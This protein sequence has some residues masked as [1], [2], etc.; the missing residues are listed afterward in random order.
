ME[1][2]VGVFFDGTGNNRTESDDIMSNIGKLSHLYR[3]NDTQLT[4]DDE[5]S[6]AMLYVRGVGT[7]SNGKNDPIDNDFGE[8][9]VKGA[10]F[11][12]GG[13]E[14]IAFMLERLDNLIDKSITSMVLD[15]FGFS[16]GAALARSFVNIIVEKN[17]D[18]N[19]KKLHLCKN[20]SV[21]FVGLYDTVGSFG[22]PGDNDDPYNFQ[23]S[24]TK[25]QYIYQITSQDELRKNFDSQTLKRTQAEV[26][27]FP[28]ESR[29]NWMVEES[30]PG[31]HSDIGGGYKSS[32]EQG[33]DNNELAKI[34]L[35]KMHKVAIRQ[36]VPFRPLKDLDHIKGH[37][38]LWKTPQIL[39]DEFSTIIGAY[40]NDSRLLRL[41]QPLK[42]TQRYL[43]V[44][45][46]NLKR[47]VNRNLYKGQRLANQKQKISRLKS[48][49]ECIEQLIIADCFAGDIKVAKVFFAR[50]EKFRKDYIHLSHNPFNS[51]LGM[52]TQFKKRNKKTQVEKVINNE[53]PAN[54]LVKIYKREIFL[55]SKRK[56]TQ[57]I[58]ERNSLIC[59]AKFVSKSNPSS[60]FPK[61]V[62]IEAW[63]N[64][65]GKDDR[66]G[67]GV[68]DNNGCVEIL[69][70]DID[71][72][73]D[74]Y[75]AFDGKGESFEIDGRQLPHDWESKDHKCRKKST[76]SNYNKGLWND[77]K[78]DDFGSKNKPIIIYV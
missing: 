41:H 75:F 27:P 19:F 40:S 59:H 68:T 74:L 20:L 76:D 13:V 46:H 47:Y 16:R 57:Y 15:V 71:S 72:D 31:V 26:L 12:T 10:A 54:Q 66:L 4:K 39:N 37:N 65:L 34:Y 11:G 63:D 23:L 1:L 48:R 18:Y 33:N 6:Y 56:A 28:I 17:F 67:A 22:T 64:D 32:F 49:I 50:Y 35:S 38:I 52:G 36:N 30:M 77:F 2:N 78:K 70:F 55:N 3:D 29:K 43:E 7:K 53:T 69:C 9:K 8:W 21:R 51:T 45:N 24:K 5:K 73:R 14:R 58:E 44:A 42:D 25:A 61:G 60:T 62:E